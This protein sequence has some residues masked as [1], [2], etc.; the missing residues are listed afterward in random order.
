MAVREHL[1]FLKLGTPD[2]NRWRKENPSVVPDLS[3]AHLRTVRLS[4]AD[5]AGANLEL[6]Y[7]GDADLSGADLSR[8]NLSQ[9]YLRSARL[10]GVMLEHA[11]VVETELSGADLS[12]GR[13]AGANLHAARLRGADLTDTDLQGATL[14]RADLRQAIAVGTNFR[15]ADLSCS[16]V[17]GISAWN[18]D[19]RGATQHDLVITP[20]DE[21]TIT[22][23]NLAIAQ[24]LYLL[25][26]NERIREVIE[27]VGKK[28]V[29][30]L[31][32]F[33]A[34]RMPVLN[35]IRDALRQQNLVPVLFDFEGPRNRD[36]TETISAL[37]HLS[38]AIIA[39]LT[40]ARSVPQ[41]LTAIVPSLP[42]VPIQPIVAQSGREYTAFEHLARYPWVA[43]V[44]RY[45]Q[46]EELIAWL[47]GA[48]DALKPGG[49][50]RNV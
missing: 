23:D 29:L 9:A 13:L 25:L 1:E 22:T 41:E 45:R 36:L 39:D 38:R 14:S 4:G 20:D 46:L 15:D 18:V 12:G 42:S 16:S 48:L 35:A 28:A 40:D 44:F 3:G 47:P 49:H 21:N 34:E 7:L 37:A 33:S 43:D 32:R 10:P 24:F 30:I 11:R 17:Y 27:T 5:L 26:H 2:W 50:P 19:L 31:G 6:T 8:A